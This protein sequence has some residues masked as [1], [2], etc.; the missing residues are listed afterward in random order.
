MATAN[1]TDVLDR[2]VTVC[3]KCLQ[4]S[5]WLGTFMCDQAQGAGTTERTVAQLGL[6]NL[7]SCEYWF[8]DPATGKIDEDAY[9]DYCCFDNTSLQDWIEASDVGE[10]YEGVQCQCILTG[11]TVQP[12]CHYYSQHCRDHQAFVR[13]QSAS[14]QA[15]GNDDASTTGSG[16]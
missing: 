8:K 13:R 5:C 11:C 16:A 6:L 12:A 1:T 3:D 14:N 7:E 10:Q 4:A 9:E 2:K 15:D